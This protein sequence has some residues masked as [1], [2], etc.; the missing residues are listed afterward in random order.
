[1]R[2]LLLSAPFGT[3]HTRAARAVETA[4]RRR[5]PEAE[6]LVVDPLAAARPTLTRVVSGAY[7]QMLKRTPWAFRY[8][9]EGA[10]RPALAKMGRSEVGRLLF[11]AMSRQILSLNRQFRPDAIV[12]THPFPLSVAA[13]LR[14][15]GKLRAGLGAI[16]TD[17]TAH[18]F[19]VTRGTDFYAIAAAGLEPELLAAGAAAE[20]VVVTGI[21]IAPG[22]DAPV[23]RRQVLERLGLTEGPLTILAMGGGLGLGPML[24]VVTALEGTGE[25]VQVIAVSGRNRNLRRQLRQRLPQ[26][27]VPMAVLGYTQRVPELMAA[28]DLLVS[29]PGGLTAA[30]ALAAR[31]PLCA[32]APL[33]GHEERNLD[34]LQ[35]AG[36]LVTVDSAAE[37]ANQVRALK[38]H[39]D[40]LAAM[41]ERAAE[42]ARPNAAA[43]VAEV[44]AQQIANRRG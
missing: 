13:N 19:W 22:F 37:L 36:V 4:L 14:A 17:F 2:V 23:D 21:P 34:F 43:A 18:P 41:R 3:G 33:P 24:D 15:R 25:G 28:A 11:L 35:R 27:G 6:T 9:Y 44:I 39:P 8:L 32:V 5:Y 20:Q 40:R 10:E 29:K 7:L 16:I 26:A 30:E 42:L 1:M 31:L 38:R 12:C